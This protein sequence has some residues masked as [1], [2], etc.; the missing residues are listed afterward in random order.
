MFSK[1]FSLLAAAAALFLAAPQAGLAQQKAE[2]KATHGAWEV[3]C[4][5]EACSMSQTFKDAQDRPVVVISL[6]KLK[7]PQKTDKGDLIAKARIITPLQVLLPQG[8]GMRIDGGDLIRAP[9]LICTPLGCESHPHVVSDALAK[10]QAGSKLEF[11]T[12]VP[13]ADGPKNVVVEMSLE[14]FSAAYGEL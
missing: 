12:A 4:K 13:T 8:V 7:E 14:G 3:H 1:R 5:G 2:L 11:L 10:L 9:Y 6:Q